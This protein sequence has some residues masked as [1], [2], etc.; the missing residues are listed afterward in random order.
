MTTQIKNEIKNRKKEI[1]SIEKFIAGHKKAWPGAVV[2]LDDK[3]QE[4]YDELHLEIR[5]LQDFGYIW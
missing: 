1:K 5:M 2:R 4:R 3:T